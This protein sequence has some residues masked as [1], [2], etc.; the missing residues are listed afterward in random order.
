[1]RKSYRRRCLSCKKLKIKC[2]GDLPNCEYCIATERSCQYPDFEINHVEFDHGGAL[3]KNETISDLARVKP[4]AVVDQ[5][6]VYG[7]NS[8]YSPLTIY[9]MTMSNIYNKTD[10]EMRTVGFFASRGSLVIGAGNLKGCQ[11]WASIG[12]Q[13][14]LENEGVFSGVMAFSTSLMNMV[15]SMLDHSI[16]SLEYF[17]RAIKNC[18]LLV[19]SPTPN[20]ALV[21]GLTSSLIF[22]YAM[23]TPVAI[24]I[25]SENE[26]QETDLV[27]LAK[28]TLKLNMNY[29]YLLSNTPMKCL[30]QRSE[31][32]EG[33]K[34]NFEFIAYLEALLDDQVADHD[35]SYAKYSIYKQTIFLLSSFWS[36]S[37]C[38]GCMNP[39]VYL[40]S[41]LPE[42]FIA[43]CRNKDPFAVV[44]FSYVAVSLAVSIFHG[45]ICNI[46]VKQV[47]NLI[48]AVP[49]Y[50]KEAVEKALRMVTRD[51]FAMD[52]SHLQ[53]LI[54]WVTPE[55]KPVEPWQVL[56]GP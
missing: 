40:L 32:F 43:L 7:D 54:R 23:T 1:M 11:M 29:D 52:V 33:M 38:D 50:L 42:D 2:S 31:L 56:I 35:M 30:I 16:S 36:K 27:G 51:E 37:V 21:M 48:L 4:R 8:Y 45:Q 25:L 9:P 53:G 22:A 49:N 14:A 55:G 17:D 44:L 47:N 15:P 34:L 20:D 3:K 26:S 28:A 19:A 46:W 12:V 10:E 39:M 5:A 13:L 18:A 41:W 24:P 6:S